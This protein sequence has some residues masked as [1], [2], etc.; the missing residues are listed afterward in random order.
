[1]HFGM[2]CLCSYRS[3][4]GNLVSFRLFFFSLFL[5]HF[6]PLRLAF[7]FLYVIPF[8]LS[9]MFPVFPPLFLLLSLIPARFPPFLSFL[10][11]LFYP[12]LFCCFFL[13][14]LFACLLSF[15]AFS[16]VL[17]L[18]LLFLSSFLFLSLSSPPSILYFLI[19]LRFSSF[20]IFLYF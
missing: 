10:F 9:C 14:F 6:C 4:I 5:V 20:F 19:P 1:M 18:S 11:D 17:L 2:S 13:C 8:F 15:I 3:Y 7:F 16:F 12:S